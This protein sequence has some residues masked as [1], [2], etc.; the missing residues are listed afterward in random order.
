MIEFIETALADG[1]MQSRLRAD[2]LPS[3]MYYS[4]TVWADGR[5]TASSRGYG[6][7]S[8]R[9]YDHASYDEAMQHATAWAK[10]KLAEERRHQ[11]SL[12]LPKLERELVRLFGR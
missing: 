3:G 4:I 1:H 5:C 9:Y 11:D 12:R 8:V 6:N 10:R 7:G 2:G